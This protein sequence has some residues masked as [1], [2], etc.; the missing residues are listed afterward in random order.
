MFKPT[1]ART[2]LR[3][4]LLASAMVLGACSPEATAPKATSHANQA[5]SLFV[6]SAA[7]KALIGVVDGTYTVV[8]DPTIDQQFNLG[9]NYLSLP[10]N[11]ICNLVTSGY[12][13]AFWNSEC[14]PATTPLTLTVVIRN[15]SSANPSLDF[16]PAMRFNPAKSVQLYIYA[17]KVTPSDAKNWLMKYCP[18]GGSCFDESLTDPSLS[19]NIDYANN[20]LFR[21]VKHFSG[22]TVAE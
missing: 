9:P 18:D 10:A 13:A 3:F 11:S 20:V 19:T 16:A 7:A 15:A 2:A 22:Y 8:V 1:K 12:G 21:R 5:T 6:P 14:T 4:T 17:P